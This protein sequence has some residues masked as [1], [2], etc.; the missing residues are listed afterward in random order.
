MKLTGRNCNILLNADP[1]FEILDFSL[2]S[3][4][5][6]VAPVPEPMT[7]VVPEPTTVT[8]PLLAM[9]NLVTPDTEAVN[10]A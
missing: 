3:E 9:V 10:G 5:Q 1:R 7:Q 2:I 8:L 6:L 4:V